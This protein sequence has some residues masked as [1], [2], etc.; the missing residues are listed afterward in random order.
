MGKSACKECR[1]KDV[2]TKA[3]SNSS[4]IQPS[5]IQEKA[6]SGSCC[7][8]NGSKSPLSR[9]SSNVLK[10]YRKR[11]SKLQM[12]ESTE[13]MSRIQRAPLWEGIKN[14]NAAKKLNNTDFVENVV[15]MEQDSKKIKNTA[16]VCD[17]YDVWAELKDGYEPKVV[18]GRVCMDNNK[19]HSGY[20]SCE[21]IVE[22][23]VVFKVNNGKYQ[24]VRLPVPIA[25]QHTFRKGEK[26]DFQ[27]LTDLVGNFGYK[28][29]K[30]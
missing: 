26:T 11:A 2:A 28:L 16:S 4:N 19:P 20:G 1:K 21:Q 10:S 7:S 15:P 8:N 3:P 13:S 9:M 30:I 5:W 18:N 12:K 27:M 17:Y 23:K 14:N 29:Q 22:E 24:Q 25:C 6:N